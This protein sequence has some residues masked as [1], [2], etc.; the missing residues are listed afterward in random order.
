MPNYSASVL[1]ILILSSAW[2]SGSAFGSYQIKGAQGRYHQHS[3]GV[4]LSSR[5]DTSLSAKKILLAFDGTGNNARDFMPNEETDVSFTNVLKL[6]I[7]AGGD[8]N[9]RRNDVPG[10]ISLY[11]RGIGGKTDVKLRRLLR[12]AGGDLSRQTKPMRQKLEAVYEKGDKLYLIGFS[13]GAASARKFATELYKEGL[14]TKDGD[15]VE[16]PPIEFLGCFETVAMQVKKRF[17]KVMR[18]KRNEN[19]TKS[20]V[21][22]EEGN[23]FPNIKKAVHNV[24]FDD[25]RMFAP[26]VWYPPVLMDSK[27]ARIHETWFAG[28]HGDVGGTYYTKGMP[29]SSCKY[30]QEW[31]ESLDDSLSFIQ[32][33]DINPECLAI[34]GYPD[35]CINVDDICI[36]PDPTDQIHL[37]EAQTKKPSYRPVVVVS[38]DKIVED[39]TV[40]VHE[41]VLYHMEAM[42]KKGTPYKINPEL[43]KAKAVIVGSLGKELQSETKRFAE[44]LESN[45]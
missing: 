25:N 21:V 11:E 33:G 32:P 42:E 9:G 35:I 10:Q 22:G 29:D 12:M 14:L 37:N 15:K 3:S 18:T 31:I 1:S 4:E 40:S 23:L 39:G 16:E 17:F 6:H 30:M 27:D 38:G 43:K 8:I 24:A 26:P 5:S 13:R 2:I 44:L 34:D 19:L 20:T 36:I 28:E 7:L 41:S 45:Y